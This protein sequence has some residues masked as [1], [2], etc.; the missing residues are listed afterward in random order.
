MRALMP[1]LFL[2]FAP[3]ALANDPP[4]NIDTQG[5]KRDTA[6][7][8]KLRSQRTLSAAAFLEKAAQD[9]VVLL[10][11]RSRRAYLQKHLK[12]ALHLNFSDFTAAKLA[13]LIP[14]PRTPI[15]IYC[16]NNILQDPV[17]FAAKAPAMA[18]NIPTFVNLYGYGYRNVYELGVSV[19]VN[20]RRFVFEGTA[21]KAQQQA[22]QRAW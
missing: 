12:G 9:G 21:V 11:T 8:L 22:V 2:I 6:A 20:D 16:N 15:L 13:K 14:D 17:A 7:A 3:P 4:S 19:D 18:L 1:L 10:D 5:F